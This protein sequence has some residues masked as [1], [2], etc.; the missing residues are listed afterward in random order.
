MAYIYLVLSE[1]SAVLI[2]KKTFKDG[3]EFDAFMGRL[4]K[5]KPTN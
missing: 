2:P 3:D 4:R 1:I 5:Y